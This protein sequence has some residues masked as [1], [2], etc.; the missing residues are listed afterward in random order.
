MNKWSRN[1]GQHEAERDRQETVPRCPQC[2]APMR[3][4]LRRSDNAPFYGCSNFP[5]CRGTRPCYQKP[6]G[7]KP[8]LKKVPSKKK[9]RQ[10]LPWSDLQKKVFK[11]VIK[12][13]KNAFVDAVAGSAKTTSIVEAMWRARE[14]NPELKVLF[15]AF[16]RSIA[17]E[18]ASRIPEGVTAMTTHSYGLNCCIRNAEPKVE[19]DRDKGHIILE[20]LL[21][22]D[23][24][25]R[26]TLRRTA[27]KLVGLGK[28]YLAKSAQELAD[29]AE[30]HGV[31][32]EADAVELA[33]RAMERATESYAVVDF[34]DMLYIPA[35][36]NLPCEPYDLVLV[37]ESQDLNM[38]Q[39]ALIEKIIAGGGRAIFVGD[40][41]Q[42]I[43][44]FRGAAT[45]AVKIITKRFKCHKLTLSVT[46]RCPKKVVELAKK[47]VPQ[48]EAAP[49][50][51]DGVVEHDVKYESM[52]KSAL[53][54]DLILC[55]TNA[56]LVSTCME[57]LREGKKVTIQGRD[58]GQNLI[59]LIKRMKAKTVPDLCAKLD[60]WRDKE[61]A[62]IMAK[63]RPS[64]IAV[65][66]I[67]DKVQTIVVFTEGAV[68][69]DDVCAAITKVFSDNSKTGIKLSSVHR[70]KGLEADVVW[71]LRPDL[72]P[73][74]KAE[75]KWEQES[76]ANLEYVAYTRA[77]RKLRILE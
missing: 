31:D 12:G 45:D 18:L 11:Y 59:A 40:P 13:K 52:M 60:V 2:D 62:K 61:V 51:P 65:E 63:K 32:C 70:A 29:I 50:A 37:D 1:Y 43:Y 47:I 7:E 17:E 67:Q 36:T 22:G 58:I 66:A 14:A 9:E 41:R 8:K 48:I 28:G 20:E 26:V 21:P 74:P 49:N 39:M 24:E 35:V 77:K 33:L 15:L 68:T 53:D 4:R 5:Q 6:N 71:I 54:G 72:M 38:A 34:D 55:R 19:L 27:H 25:E 56:P 46:Y 42:A 57:F 73:H 69:P 30:H 16:N 10:Q 44:Q 3:K 64:E 76:E 75:Q 23:E